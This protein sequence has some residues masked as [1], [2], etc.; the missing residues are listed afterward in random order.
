MSDSKKN[1]RDSGVTSRVKTT[2][3]NV[4]EAHEALF[5]ATM[6]LPAASAHCGM[7]QKELK[8]TFFE[9]LKYNAPNFEVPKDTP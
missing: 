8:M 7:T 3:Q 9:Y 6:N 5:Y 4:K 1:Q 2:P